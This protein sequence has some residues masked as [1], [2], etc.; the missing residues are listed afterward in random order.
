VHVVARLSVLGARTI[1]RR[2]TRFALTA[3][4]VSLGIA[5]LFAVLITNATITAGL[6]GY[7]ATND[8][9]QVTIQP[10]GGYDTDLQRSVVDAA[11]RL[12][13]VVDVSGGT[14]VEVRIPGAGPDKDRVYLYGGFLR[15][16][17]AR[18]PHHTPRGSDLVLKGRAAADGKDEVVISDAIA[19]QMH[20]D[21]GATVEFIGPQGALRML[22]VGRNVRRDGKPDDNRFAS[23]SYPTAS[24]LAAR[25]EVVSYGNIRLAKGTD[26]VRW[27]NAHRRELGPSV[28]LGGST[29]QYATVFRNALE[30]GRAALAG[31]AG[32]A[33]F[34]SGFLIFLTLSVTV[35]EATPIHGTLRALGASRSQVR[36]TVLA[37]ALVLVALAIPLGIVLGLVGAVGTIGLTR[38]AFGL[39]S[40]KMSVP[41]AAAAVSVAVGIVVTLIAAVLPAR[42][43]ASV[44]PVVAMRGGAAPRVGIGRLWVIGVAMIA[45]GLGVVAIS[46]QKRVDVGSIL[47]LFGA[48]MVVPALMAPVAAVA[49]FFTRRAAR[50]VGH[51]GVLY[52]RKEPRRS[53]YILGLVMVVL[54]MVFAAGSVHLSMHR[55]MVNSIS[56]EF[57]ADLAV[58]AADRLDGA[59]I[60]QVA[61]TPGVRGYAAVWRTATTEREPGTSGV[62]LTIIEPE[63]FFAI[64]GFTWADG[65]NVSARGALQRGGAVLAPDSI[66]RAQ[67]LHRGSAV[68]LETSTGTR[69]FTV[70]GVYRS[71]QSFAPFFMSLEDGRSSFKVNAPSALAVAVT[72]GRP[73]AAVKAAIEGR[74]NAGSLLFVRV[75]SV[76]KARIVKGQTQ[77]F[78]L[79][80]AIV[81]IAVIMGMLGVTNTLAMAVLRRT[82]EIGILRA[83][84]TERRQLRRMA[85]VESA[86]VALSGLV[87]AIPLGLLLSYTV[88]QT[89][90]RTLGTVVAYT[91]PWPMFAAVAPL[92]LVV[93]VASSIV[94]GRHAARVDPAR[95]LRFD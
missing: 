28:Q 68:V 66:A 9:P 65:D 17:R 31:L 4:G 77:F 73:P 41:P 10:V 12:P 21:V 59:A 50:G 35:A 91:Y 15:T 34:V 49:G 38:S 14:G 78:Q 7:L 23:T 43:A 40:L 37:D 5:V 67:R 94:P 53:A 95:V 13:D 30:T 46:S 26:G 87:L 33:L 20:A 36:R 76:E 61:A 89:V 72:P 86:T 81:L 93:A 27:T 69:R 18:P 84:G 88:L 42:R 8:V 48:V 80:Y 16:G 22:V 70:A 1:R 52:L 25:G 85:L 57:P 54:A 11:A 51:I 58:V 45:A 83:V 29:N 56:Q 92:A 19:R 62:D 63:K 32:I 75:T 82:R 3:L 6:E 24:R 71:F 90:T 60:A 79:V 39:P 64:Q 55:S 47:I 74:A 44:A 2:L